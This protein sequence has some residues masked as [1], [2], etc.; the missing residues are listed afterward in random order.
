MITVMS[1]Q[2]V[3][4]F[5]KSIEAAAETLFETKAKFGNVTQFKGRFR[6][7]AKKSLIGMI[8]LAGGV[9]AK[10]SLCIALEDAS[11]MVAK[12]LYQDDVDLSDLPDGVGEILNVIAGGAKT[13][14]N[15]LDTD[16]NLSL[17]VPNVCTGRNMLLHSNANVPSMAIPVLIGASKFVLHW[18][19]AK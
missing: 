3:Q 1:E 8:G 12:M 13:R 9:R 4:P 19:V 16:L 2:F 15:D 18:A 11:L 6:S 5:V 14:V 17:T 7:S 10:V